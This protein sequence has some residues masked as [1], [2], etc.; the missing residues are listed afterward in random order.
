MGGQAGGAQLQ[1]PHLC[2]STGQID[3]GLAEGGKVGGG[4]E[5]E[6]AAIVLV[7]VFGTSILKTTVYAVCSGLIGM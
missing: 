2:Y 5:G 3:L 4:R 7:E 1:R 6:E